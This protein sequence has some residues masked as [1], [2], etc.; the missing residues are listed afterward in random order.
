MATI[1][2]I[3]LLHRLLK[4]PTEGSWLEFKQSNQDP[5]MI[6]ECIS[7]CANAAILA[8]KERAYLVFGIEDKT[9]RKIGTTVRLDG[10][11]V[12]GENFINWISRMVEPRL[13]ME[14]LDF[15]IEGQQFSIIT[16][17]PTYD[18]PVRFSG[19]EYIRIGENTKKLADYPPHER[20]LWLATGRHKFE[21]AIA[22][23]HQPSHKVLKNLDAS[24]FY[25]LLKEDIPSTESEI[26]RRFMREGFIVDDMEGGYDVTNLGAILFATDITLFPSI[27]TK[28]VRVI[29]YVGTDKRKSEK[30]EVEGKRGY[31][32]G[33]SGLMK[34]IIGQLPHEEKYI[35]GIRNLVPVYPETAIREVIA[36]ALIHQDFTITG[37]GPIIEI[38][39]D[40]VEVTNPGNSLIEVDRIIDERRSRNEKLAATMRQLGLCEER[41]GGIDKAI[42]EIEETNLPAPEF[43]SSENS[44]RVTLFG[45]K[46]FGQLSKAEK[47]RAC[48]FHCV[49]QWIKR[50]PMS[51]TSLRERFRLPQEEYQA[52]SA[53]IS[54]SVKKK[55]IRPADTNQGN[56]NARYIPYWVS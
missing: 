33:F 34:F 1:D 23:T 35:D 9:K 31:A 4:E 49:L 29:K 37:V 26:I 18:R 24:T 11:K 30:P 39:S 14:F 7:A 10:M 15:T 44:M 25:K 50:D 55:R 43:S 16:I 38:Y 12:G 21:G 36:N 32:V 3:A 27:S 20:S 52:V 22:S 5:K 13:L 46:E 56:R 17:E 48:F 51:N 6:G 53:I 40:R 45:P 2:P 19:V 41:G 54:E 8:G 47:L 42:I 28:S